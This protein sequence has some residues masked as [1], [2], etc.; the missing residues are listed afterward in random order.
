[1]ERL[2]AA[3]LLYLTVVAILL[4]IKPSFMFTEEG[5]W[6]EFGIG[7]NPATHTWM[8]FWLFAVLWALI[9][10]ILTI[11]LFAIMGRRSAPIQSTL[12]RM[13]NLPPLSELPEISE[14]VAELKPE[15]FVKEVSKNSRKAR[16]RGKP[17]ELPDGY[18]MMNKEASEAAG[19]V[20]KYVYIG[21]GL[22]E[23]SD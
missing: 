17:T 3:G 6:K 12:P 14:E 21:K 5:A 18:Y 20:P 8:P 19:G 2:L 7:R 13:K 10:Y 15:D 16:L 1:M 22:P 23:G 9:S 11:L 4:A